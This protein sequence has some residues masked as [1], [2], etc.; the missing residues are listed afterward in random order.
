MNNEISLL[1]KASEFFFLFGKK[2]PMWVGGVVNNSNTW[3]YSPSTH[4]G[5]FLWRSLHMRP[6]VIISQSL[7]VIMHNSVASK[8]SKMEIITVEK[9]FPLQLQREKKGSWEQVEKWPVPGWTF[10]AASRPGCCSQ[11]P[12]RCKLALLPWSVIYFIFFFWD[13]FHMYGL[14]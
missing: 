11:M 5:L 2:S 9:L 8:Q 1:G 4:L 7:L 14:F 6:C 3:L 10:T 13:I 12:L